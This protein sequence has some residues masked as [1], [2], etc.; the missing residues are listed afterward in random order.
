MTS[1]K[2]YYKVEEYLEDL[3][4]F[5]RERFIIVRELILGSN[6]NIIE[7]ISF[8]LPF[9]MY[10][11]FFLYLGIYKKNN[12][13]LAFC[14]GAHLKDESGI[15]QA[16][17]KQQQMRHWVLSTAEEPDYELLSAYLEEALLVNDKLNNKWGN[18]KQIN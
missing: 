8:N 5:W 3:P 6:R 14:R 16:D 2:K 17:A 15:L 18:G 4:P 9:Y 12:L 10:K 13:V 11:G 7:K 1:G